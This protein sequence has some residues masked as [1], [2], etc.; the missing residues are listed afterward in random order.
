MSDEIV[1]Q[2]QEQQLEN[3]GAGKL[4]PVGESIKYRRRA[5]QAEARLTELDRTVKDLQSQLEGRGEELAA[6]E[7]QRDE[8]RSG[9]VEAQNRSSAERMLMQSGVVDLETAT[10][11]LSKRVDLASDIEPQALTARIEQLLL[12]KPFLLGVGVGEGG[13]QRSLP[14]KT[15]SGRQGRQG[16]PARLA[17]AAQQAV[18]T[19][20]RRDI[21]QYLRL[22][23]QAAS[24]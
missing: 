19:G 14:P 5:Q 24:R 17:Q 9:L 22:R 3:D 8:A 12:D 1:Q 13:G 4:V 11:L 16:I 7:A 2:E 23:R 6:A 18:A 20:N 21:A 10:M 15:A